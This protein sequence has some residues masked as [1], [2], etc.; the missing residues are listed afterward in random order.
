[1]G[2]GYIRIPT[3]CPFR[4]QIYFNG[5]NLLAGKLKK[6]GMAYTVMDNAFDSIEDPRRAQKISDSLSAEELRGK[7][8]EPAWKY[9]P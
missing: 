6:E 3:W 9:C 1:L 7:F 5:H 8:D 2:P 4:L